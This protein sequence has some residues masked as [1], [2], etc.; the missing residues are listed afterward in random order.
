MGK[1]GKL[2]QADRERLARMEEN[3]KKLRALA[4]RGQAELDRKKREAEASGSS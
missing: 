3:T 2:T 1:K 4:E